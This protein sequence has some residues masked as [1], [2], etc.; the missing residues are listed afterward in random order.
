MNFCRS[1]PP[2]PFI[3][4]CEWGPWAFIQV[5]KNVTI[6]YTKQPFFAFPFM[7]YE[8]EN[9]TTMGSTPRSILLNLVLIAGLK[10][11]Q[12]QQQSVNNTP[13]YG[14]DMRQ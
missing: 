8:R 7:L 1:P 2:P 4:I 13:I 3:K 12:Q 9:T 10:C 5:P 6:S 11:I 14:S